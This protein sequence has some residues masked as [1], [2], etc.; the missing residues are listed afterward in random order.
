MSSGQQW[1]IRDKLVLLNACSGE[2][3]LGVLG[4]SRPRP[5]SRHSMARL[6]R[7]SSTAMP[8]PPSLQPPGT[9]HTTR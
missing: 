8:A 2:C 5:W 1:D 7:A 3:M 4:F 9:D 6:Q